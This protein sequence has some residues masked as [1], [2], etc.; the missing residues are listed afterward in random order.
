MA[1]GLEAWL[2]SVAT[3]TLLNIVLEDTVWSFS[4]SGIDFQYYIL[5]LTSFGTAVLCLPEENSNNDDLAN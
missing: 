4:I 5:V 3:N 1:D 2:V